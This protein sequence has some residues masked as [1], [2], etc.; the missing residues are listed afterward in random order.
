[1]DDKLWIFFRNNRLWN[2]IFI[3]NLYRFIK[4]CIYIILFQLV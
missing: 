2:F 4:E 3:Y 1:L